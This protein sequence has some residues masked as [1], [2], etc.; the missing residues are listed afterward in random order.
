MKSFQGLAR[1]PHKTLHRTLILKTNT[2]TMTDRQSD[3]LRN[4]PRGGLLLALAA[5]AVNS[6]HP[7]LRQRQSG[8]GLSMGVPDPVGR[9]GPP[10]QP[11][12]CTA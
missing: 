1:D 11:A 2:G 4:S 12:A 10:P 6:G 3:Y 9:A 8:H 7:V 5:P